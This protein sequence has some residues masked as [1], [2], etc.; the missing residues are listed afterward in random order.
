MLQYSMLMRTSNGAL[1]TRRAFLMRNNRGERVRSARE[2][3]TKV[4]VARERPMMVRY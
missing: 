4:M 1:H 3:T 2:P